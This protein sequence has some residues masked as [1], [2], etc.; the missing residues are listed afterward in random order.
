MNTMYLAA[1]VVAEL[2]LARSAGPPVAVIEAVSG[3]PAEVEFIMDYVEVGKVIHLNPQDGIV[4]IAL[5]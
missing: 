1:A 2:I 5:F 4:L 3:N